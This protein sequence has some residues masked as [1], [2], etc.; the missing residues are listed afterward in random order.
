MAQ[1]PTAP[2]DAKALFEAGMN[3]I[4]GTGLSRNDV[5]AVEYFRQ[6][7][8]LGYAPAQDVI[9]Y[10]AENGKVV[11][12]DSHQALVWYRKAASQGDR[13]AQWVIGRMYFTGTGNVRDLNEAEN[14][15]KKAS[16]QGDAFG[17]F[18]LGS[19]R[20]ERGDYA[21]AATSF[22]EAAE[23]GL[24]QAQHQ[25]VILLKRSLGR[26]PTDKFE[27]YVWL[28]LA[29]EA[30]D[31]SAADDIRQLEG[32]L[33]STNVERAKAEVRGRQTTLSRSLLANGCTGWKGEFNL[34]PTTPPPDLHRFCQ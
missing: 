9:G 4:S 24:P 25:L 28:L 30:A 32:D 3:G 5:T 13:L 10:F 14:W 15:L 27:A 16:D 12:Q 33:G 21:N 8:E 29:F 23:Q 18:L 6:S 20:L 2:L 17:Q 1:Q 34:L 7:A 31:Q 26:V 22:R 19:V 11:P